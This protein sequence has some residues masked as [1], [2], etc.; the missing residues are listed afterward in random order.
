MHLPRLPHAR[1]PGSPD[2]SS[3]PGAGQ[4]ARALWMNP[5]PASGRRWREAPDE[6]AFRTISRLLLAALLIASLGACGNL[7]RSSLDAARLAIG[8]N[9]LE[10]DPAQVAA[11]PYAQIR[12]DSPDGPS[13]MVLG[14][15]DDGLTSWYSPGRIVFLRN[16]VLAGNHGLAQDAVDIRLLGDDPFQR[17]A[18]VE[19]ARTLRRYDWMPGHRFG[20]EVTGEL[21][22]GPVETVDILGTIHRLQ[23]FDERLAGPG[24]EATNSYWAEPGTGVIHRS[25]QFAAPDVMLEVTVLKPYQPAGATL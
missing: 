25:R 8:S 22:R 20:V 7:A 24:V 1:P 12:V 15:D 23:R 17:L 21:V 2:P 19:R 5:S 4:R 9:T 14:N 16:G 10:I 3:I 13:L 18:Q 11:S 6:G